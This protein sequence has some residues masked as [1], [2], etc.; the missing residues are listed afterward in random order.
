M[1]N[2][3]PKL[4]IRSLHLIHQNKTSIKE[5]T[6]N[7]ILKLCHN[8]ITKTNKELKQY[9][10][11]YLPPITMS[12]RPVYNYHELISFIIIKL[13]ENGLKSY[14]DNIKKH[15]YISWKPEDVSCNNYDDNN[16][17]DDLDSIFNLSD[18]IK[19]LEINPAESNNTKKGKSKKNKTNQVEHVAF[20]KYGNT[21]ITDI[22]P[23]NL[24]GDTRGDTH[25][26][27]L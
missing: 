26:F 23:V 21:N 10:C 20:V 6:F 25:Q 5:Q 14:W 11:L 22:L 9:E 17:D 18:N 16:E 27:R 1:A 13:R 8:K 3:P 7:E 15:I 2:D 24:G 4:D 12:G 19:F